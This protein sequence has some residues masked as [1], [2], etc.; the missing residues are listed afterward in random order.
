MSTLRFLADESCDFAV[1]R[2]LRAAGFDVLA[3]SEI[4]IRSIDRD[5]IEQANREQRI[6]IT[7][8]KDFGWLVFASHVDSPGVILI[9]FPGNLRRTLAA[10][11]LGL[12]QDQGENLLG[13]FVVVQPGRTR[14]SRK[15]GYSPTP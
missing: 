6:L 2:S 7:E 10:T 9:R 3:I 1:V 11:V 13:G 12:V 8:D 5:L 4:M 15:S 14:I